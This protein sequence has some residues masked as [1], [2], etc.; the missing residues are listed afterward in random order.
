MNEEEQYKCDTKGQTKKKEK[1]R[2]FF[3][4]ARNLPHFLLQSFLAQKG[5][6]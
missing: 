6:R 2:N 4:F 3:F 1:R 5:I